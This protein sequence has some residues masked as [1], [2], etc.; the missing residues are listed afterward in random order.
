VNYSSILYFFEF[1]N[2]FDTQKNVTKNFGKD[3]SKRGCGIIGKILLYV[4]GAIKSSVLSMMFI[5]QRSVES[6]PALSIWRPF[7]VRQQ[8]HQ[9]FY[10]STINAPPTINPLMPT[11]R[12]FLFRDVA[13]AIYP[14]SG[15]KGPFGAPGLGAP[16]GPPPALT[17]VGAVGRLL[18]VTVVEVV[19][20]PL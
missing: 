13:A 5:N 7:R 10:Y 16:L 2:F 6:G 17:L 14:S 15:P 4:R 1:L 8:S 18:G 11:N 20:L 9:S 3:C 19:E 12:A